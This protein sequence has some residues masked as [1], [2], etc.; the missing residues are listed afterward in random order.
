MSGASAADI[1]DYLVSFGGHREVN[2]AA[3]RTVV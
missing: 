3:L 1:D 2:L